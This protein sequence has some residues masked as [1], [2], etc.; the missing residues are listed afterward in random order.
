MCRWSRAGIVDEVVIV[1][2]LI[3][4]DQYNRLGDYLVEELGYERGVDFFEFAYDWRQDVRTSARQLG[5]FFD[6]LPAGQAGDSRRAQPGHDGQPLLR[7]AAGRQ[8]AR[9]APGA[10]G[11]PAPGRGQS[12]HQPAAS[13]RR[14]L[15]FGL[16][17]ERL[18]Q[19]IMTF[20]TSY[21]IMPDLPAAPSTRTARRSISW[22]TRAG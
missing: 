14:V 18:R 21:Q 11:R 1:P 4:Q 13:P 2:N 12:P 16:M 9:R 20:P 7:R 5:K 19:V 3:K 22:K 15:P 6:T 17:G 8:K 10:D